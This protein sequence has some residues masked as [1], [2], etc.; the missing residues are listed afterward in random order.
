MVFVRRQPGGTLFPDRLAADGSVDS[1]LTISQA[2]I[3][4]GLFNVGGA[5]GSLAVGLLLDRAG[6]KVVVLAFLLATP[7]VISLG[8]I[9]GPSLMM[10]LM[11]V[12]TVAGGLVLGGQI[13][14]NA[15]SGIVYPTAMRSTGS[16]WAFGVGRIGSIS[17]PIIGGDS[18]H[19][20]IVATLV[21]P[22]GIGTFVPLRPGDAGHDIAHERRARSRSGWQHGGQSVHSRRGSAPCPVR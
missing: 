5:V 16:G 7:V 14:L 22:V 2:N 11:L 13:G 10:L 12:V 3:A 19:D 4:G 17:G 6:I 21:V 20:G 15:L 18:H 8:I 1:G 9:S